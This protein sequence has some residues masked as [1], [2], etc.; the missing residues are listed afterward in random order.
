MGS[1]NDIEKPAYLSEGI[2][3]KEPEEDASITLTDIYQFLLF[4][5][6]IAKSDPIL[7]DVQTNFSTIKDQ[8]SEKLRIAQKSTAEKLVKRI[9]KKIVPCDASTQTA[10]D[11]MHDQMQLLM[12]K[13]MDLYRK[14]FDLQEE[15]KKL[16][17]ELTK[18]KSTM[19]RQEREL[20]E[21]Q[22]ETQRLDQ[23]LKEQSKNTSMSKKDEEAMQRMLSKIDQFRDVLQ[24]RDKQISRLIE[25]K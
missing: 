9:Y 15:N 19:S 10:K 4:E 17:E 14:K 24:K 2:P 13:E 25:E 18:L 22:K 12:D 11:P 1:L 6:E 8:L 3:L 7:K 23:R 20:E 5:G 21:T 16:K